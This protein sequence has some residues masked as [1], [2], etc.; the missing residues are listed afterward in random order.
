MK[1]YKLILL[2]P[3]LL[4]VA[5][6]GT[7]KRDRALTGAGI[8]AGVGAATGAITNTGIG[9]GAALGGAAGA[10]TGALTEE[11]DFERFRFW[12]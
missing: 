6:C 5:A 2:L 8:G 4:A 7:D 12:D 9:T 3:L 1:F 11:G 10:A